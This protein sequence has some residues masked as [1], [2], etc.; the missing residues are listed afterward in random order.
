[1]DKSSIANTIRERSPEIKT[2]FKAEVIGIFGSY[3][4]GEQHSDSDVDVL[5]R[6]ESG[7]TLFDLVGLSDYLGLILG[8]PVDVVSE[9]ALHP[10]MHDDVM[11]ELVVV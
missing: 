5:V 4:R 10:M 1:M 6:F 11:N 9:R 3:A 8:V 7:A 2:Q